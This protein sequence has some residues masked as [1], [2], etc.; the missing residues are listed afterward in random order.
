MRFSRYPRRDR[1]D[2]NKVVDRLETGSAEIKITAD[3]EHVARDHELP[4]MFENGS[5]LKVCASSI[6]SGGE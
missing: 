6:S 1:N 4:A 3:I 2:T 5:R